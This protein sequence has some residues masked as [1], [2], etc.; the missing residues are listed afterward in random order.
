M[1]TNRAARQRKAFRDQ[2]LTFLKARI[3]TGQRARDALLRRLDP[4]YS[5]AHYDAYIDARRDGRWQRLSGRQRRWLRWLAIEE[6]GGMP[7]ILRVIQPTS[8]PRVMRRLR[9]EAV[10]F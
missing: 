5:F 2:Y 4:S 6:L 10:P 3:N 7:V 8:D 1:L 9:W